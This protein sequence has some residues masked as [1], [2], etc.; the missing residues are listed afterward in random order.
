MQVNR[1]KLVVGLYTHPEAYPPTLNALNNLC[2]IFDE[3]NLVHSNVMGTNW[4]Y[5]QNTKLKA[6]GYF[7]P[8]RKFEQKSIFY[9]LVHFCKYTIALYKQSKNANVVLLYDAM[10]L[11]AYKIIKPFVSNK[12]IW[13]HNHDVFEPTLLRKYS[14]SWL[15]YKNEKTAFKWIDIFSLPSNERKQFFNLQQFK[16]EYCYIPNFPSKY[17]YNQFSNGNQI[18]NTCRI[19]YQG[20]IGKGHAIEEIIAIIS[21]LEQT[22]SFNFQLVL[23]GFISEEYENELLNLATQYNVKEKLEFIGPTPYKE[24]PVVTASC[25]IG[26]AI[27]TGGDRMNT[28]LGTASNKIYE[29]AACG[30]PV[31]YY[32]NEHYSKYLQN[33]SWAKACDIN[34]DSLIENIVSIVKD[35][36]QLSTQ[37][38]IDFKN[39]LNFE[40]HFEKPMTYLTQKL[41]K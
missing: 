21:K 9:K 35:Y 22:T 2:K 8:I 5:P 34:Q 13:Y 18:N 33:Y 16:G 27:H 15:A 41:A 40:I 37:A 10:P 31:L 32:N 12:V 28:T 38:T 1:N 7:L 6:I 24:V 29:Y 4:T 17:F 26:I 14:I 36:T 30:L 39:G 25:N 20:S 11:L 3:V 23:K 19:L